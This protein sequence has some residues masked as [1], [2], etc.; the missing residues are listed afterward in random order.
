M[1]AIQFLKKEHVTAKAA[2]KGVLQASPAK[3]GDLWEKL[4]PELEAH[5]QIEDACL[6]TPLSRDAAGKDP[7]LA[8]WREKHQAE[9]EKV[10]G[11]IEEIDDLDPED[12][13]WLSTVKKVHTSL[14]N[15]IREEEEDVFSR[16]GKVWDAARLTDAGAKME[17]MKGKK[18]AAA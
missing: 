15:H 6:Y 7:K 12:E 2:F 9:V 11:L 1:D 3:R 8:G 5:E 4:S 10:K 17:Q 13:K 14:E 16:I 18:A